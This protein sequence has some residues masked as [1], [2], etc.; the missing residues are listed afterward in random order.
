LGLPSD[1]KDLEKNLWSFFVCISLSPTIFL[2]E[3]PKL[4]FFTP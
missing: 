3:I 4:P 1:I 2:T